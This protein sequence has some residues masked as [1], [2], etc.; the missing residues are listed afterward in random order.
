MNFCLQISVM[1]LTDSFI[2]YKTRKWKLLVSG[3]I[4]A[5]VWYST[6]SSSEWPILHLSSEWL[7]QVF[8]ALTR[9]KEASRFVLLV[10]PEA[11]ANKVPFP[12]AERV[13][14]VRGHLLH[15]LF[16]GCWGEFIPLLS[17]I[18]CEVWTSWVSSDVPFQTCL[19]LVSYHLLIV[20]KVSLQ[21]ACSVIWGWLATTKGFVPAA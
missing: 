19:F 21:N 11:A 13:T 9:S 2:V 18:F 12:L 10:P 3:T 7:E 5:P 4:T 1:W 17:K 8:C 20:L 16:L 6:M 15:L 14:A